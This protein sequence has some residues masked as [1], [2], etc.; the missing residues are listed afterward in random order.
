MDARTPDRRR[1]DLA[2]ILEPGLDR[3]EPRDPAVAFI[4]GGLIALVLVIAAVTGLAGLRD[5][6]REVRRVLVER[7]RP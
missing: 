6:V 5:D 1:A 7:C 2:R 4:A 3:P